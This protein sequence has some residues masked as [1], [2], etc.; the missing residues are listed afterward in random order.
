MFA[1]EVLRQLNF[2]DV[3]SKKMMECFREAAMSLGYA[4][5]KPEQEKVLSEFFKEKMSLY[6]SPPDLARNA[7]YLWGIVTYAHANFAGYDIT[8]VTFRT[9]HWYK[10]RY[11]DVP[12]PSCF[13]YEGMASQTTHERGRSQRCRTANTS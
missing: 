3:Q 11:T 5:L 10:R 12:R 1:Y 2:S 13:M 4:S 6:L 7:H 9:F 8:N